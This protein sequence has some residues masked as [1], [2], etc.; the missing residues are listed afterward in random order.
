GLRSPEDGEEPAGRAGRAGPSWE[1]FRLSARR[2]LRGAI[3]PR[4]RIVALAGTLAAIIGANSPWATFAFGF[5]GKMTLAGFPGG[6][7]L[8]TL[9][10]SVLA[11]VVLVDVPARRRVGVV[12]GGGAVANT[13]WTIVALAN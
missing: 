9:L 4:W 10:L 11:L 7:R 8:F 13:A 1:R 2:G 6:A 3:G 12:A 5:P